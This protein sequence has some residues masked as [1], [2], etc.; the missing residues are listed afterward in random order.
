MKNAFNKIL[1]LFFI[2]DSLYGDKYYNNCNFE[3][4][5][6]NLLIKVDTLD[7]LADKIVRVINTE[8]VIDSLKGD[9]VVDEQNFSDLEMP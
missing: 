9:G 1:K 3:E 8:N 6:L 4:I 2:F 7:N 5:R